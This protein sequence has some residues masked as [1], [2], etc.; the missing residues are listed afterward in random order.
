MF[1]ENITTNQENLERAFLPHNLLTDNDL[2]QCFIYL[3]IQ[4]VKSYHKHF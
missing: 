3:R 1:Q 4:L 2:E